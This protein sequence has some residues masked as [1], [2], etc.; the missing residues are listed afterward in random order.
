[1][2]T[3]PTSKEQESWIIHVNLQPE[4]TCDESFNPIDG[5]NDLNYHWIDMDITSSDTLT[6]F[7]LL[8]FV[9]CP[10]YM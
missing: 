8:N 4:I 7:I 2:H 9:Y 5:M 6:T 3:L 1:M 10:K